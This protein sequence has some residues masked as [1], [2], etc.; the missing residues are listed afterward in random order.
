MQVDPVRAYNSGIELARLEVGRAPTLE[1][2]CSPCTTHL[3]QTHM[4]ASYPACT[5]WQCMDLEA[6][7]IT[8]RLRRS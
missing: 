4:P 8:Q 6:A 1:M 2:E 3:F 5:A 7:S